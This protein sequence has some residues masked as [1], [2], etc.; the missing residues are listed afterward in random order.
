[1]YEMKAF[2]WF[3]LTNCDMGMGLRNIYEK[4]PYYCFVFYSSLF[5]D[6]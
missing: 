4:K 1:M 3:L 6:S 5:F 2:S